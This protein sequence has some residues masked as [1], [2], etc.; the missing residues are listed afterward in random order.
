MIHTASQTHQCRCG[1]VHLPHEMAGEAGL[2]R[3][4]RDPVRRIKSIEDIFVTNTLKN[5]MLTAV[6]TASATNPDFASLHTSYSTTGA[7]EHSTS[8][9]SPVYSRVAVTW[10]APA[11]GETH[12]VA[13]LPSINMPAG[14]TAEFLGLWDAVSAGNFLAMQGLGAQTLKPAMAEA[15]D[16]TANDIFCD[17]HGYVLDNRVIFWSASGLALPTGL[18]TG[19]TYWVISTGLATDSFRVSTTQGGAAVDITDPTTLTPFGFF[20]Q[21]TIP[22]TSV[23]QDVVNVASF[24]F[25]LGALGL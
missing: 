1:S 8:G 16:I 23:S 18:T 12:M 19:V 10:S 17:S 4:L 9:G 11:T 15:A 20:V 13:T 6:A 14:R 21:R 24:S 3:Q 25:D 22:Q 7:N 5:L 2:Y